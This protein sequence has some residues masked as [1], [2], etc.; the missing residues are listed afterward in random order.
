MGQV[1]FVDYRFFILNEESGTYTHH[2]A[3]GFEFDL[4]GDLD[5]DVTW[6]WDRIQDPRQN[7]DGSFPEQDDLR[8]MFGLGF[9]F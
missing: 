4:I 3:T 2:L 5:F 6:V 9:S 7:S 1:L 8:M